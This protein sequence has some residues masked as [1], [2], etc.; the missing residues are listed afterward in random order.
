ML[1]QMATRHEW[2]RVV[3]DA[4]KQEFDLTSTGANHS[5]ALG[6]VV[7][8]SQSGESIKVTWVA[9]QP[10][11]DDPVSSAGGFLNSEE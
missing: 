1:E 2:S 11:S 9:H 6:H 3:A 4:M 8:A 10:I 7:C 5:A